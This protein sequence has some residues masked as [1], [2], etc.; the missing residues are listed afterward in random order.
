MPYHDV[1]PVPQTRISI[2]DGAIVREAVLPCYGFADMTPRSPGSA[3]SRK[4]GSSSDARGIDITV[5]EGRVSIESSIVMAYG[6]PL[7][8]V[9]ATARQAVSFPAERVDVNVQGLYVSP[10][11][12]CPL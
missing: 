7:F 2:A 12:R 5:D 8:T 6:A 3:I 10:A 9:A 4:P 11:S 1:Q